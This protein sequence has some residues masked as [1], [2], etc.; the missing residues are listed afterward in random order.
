[1]IKLIR[2]LLPDP[3]LP[4]TRTIDGLVFFSILILYYELQNED[5]FISKK[6]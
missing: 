4:V 3:V 2:V 1:M 5:I 6:S